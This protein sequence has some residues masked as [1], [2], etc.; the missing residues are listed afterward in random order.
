MQQTSER[1]VIVLAFLFSGRGNHFGEH[2]EEG[3]SDKV[4]ML[5]HLS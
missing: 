2:V 1:G 5:A 4:G 3:L